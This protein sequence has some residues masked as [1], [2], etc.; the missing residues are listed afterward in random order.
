MGFWAK[1]VTVPIARVTLTGRRDWFPY[2]T[3]R[4]SPVS[5]LKGSFRS[6]LSCG[7]VIRKLENARVPVPEAPLRRPR[8]F[9]YVIRGQKQRVGLFFS[10][11][12]FILRL[13]W[14]WDKV[15]CFSFCQLGVTASCLGGCRGPDALTPTRRRHSEGEGTAPQGGFWARMCLK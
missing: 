1:E 4:W 2:G 11:H 9:G 6:V 7:K 3:C 12:T 10:S 5:F 14:R 8:A 15:S 13:P